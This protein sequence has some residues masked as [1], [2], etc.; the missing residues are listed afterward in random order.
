MQGAQIPP[1][2]NGQGD[3]RP[4]AGGEPALRPL[5]L[6]AGDMLGHDGEGDLDTAAPLPGETQRTDTEQE[7]LKGRWG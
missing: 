4:D 6:S 1:H 3:M 2:P 7:V 5:G